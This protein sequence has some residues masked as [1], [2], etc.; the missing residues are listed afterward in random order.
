M[1]LERVVR[2]TISAVALVMALYR[3]WV[4][5]VGPPNA[6]VPRSV[7]VGFALTLAFLAAPWHKRATPE[8][9]QLWDW[10]LIAVGVVATAY[11]VLF[12]DYF[13]TRM[14]YVDDPTLADLILGYALVVLV[15]EATPRVVGPALPATAALFILYALTR[16]SRTR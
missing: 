2:L 14:Y 6:L 15:L 3:L 8:R 9:P 5:F 4:A 7:H 16:G 13:L 12:V 11:P 1:K 10:A